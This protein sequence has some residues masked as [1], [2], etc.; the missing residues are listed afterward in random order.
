M[1][2][3]TAKEVARYIVRFAQDKGEPITNL[4]LQKLLYYAQGWHLVFFD[5]P[6]FKESIQAWVH[7]PVVPS[8]YSQF[9]GYGFNPIPVHP[10]QVSLSKTL[11][12]F[13]SELL[14]TYL[15][16]DAFALERMTHQEEPWKE[17][18]GSLPPTQPCKNVISTTTMKRFFKKQ[19][20]G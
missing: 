5:K 11:S 17:A 15:R 9:K 6:L 3:L 1:A 18:R 20:D 4:K 7:G 16:F 10:H 2:Q 8:V 13:I 12:G 19:L 14:L